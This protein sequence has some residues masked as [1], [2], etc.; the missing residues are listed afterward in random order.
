MIQNRLLHVASPLATLHNMAVEA[1]ERNEQIDPNAL[2][3]GVEYALILLGNA[4]STCLYERQRIVLKALNPKLEGFAEKSTENPTSTEL[5]GPK[6]RR[7]IKNHVELSK[8]VSA[9]ERS[10][11]SSQINR[12]KWT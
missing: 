11:G 1:R 9:F 10:L 8:E 5:F 2:L 7:D 6:L 12:P 4:N 3:K